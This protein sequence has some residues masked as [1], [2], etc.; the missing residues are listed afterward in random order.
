M[1]DVSCCADQNHG[2]ILK[3]LSRKSRH[4]TIEINTMRLLE[5]PSA[6]RSSE[7]LDAV[8]RSRRLHAP[9]AYPPATPEAIAAYLQRLR[10][11]ARLG[12]WVCT[13]NSE[14][15]GVINIGEIVRGSFCS[16][17]L[18]YYAFLPHNGRGYMKRGLSAV[19]SEAF[20]RHGLHR[21]EA[22]IQPGNAASRALVERLGFRM[23]GFSPRYLKIG[24]RWRDHERWAITSEEWKARSRRS[25]P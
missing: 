7:F 22:N 8:R 10:P 23:E 25:V 19:L 1:I 24:G 9:W 18:G 17:Y 4:A 13:E 6:K 14:L 21:L 2:L 16:G 11:P 5:T 12:Y 3:A 15:A 20:S